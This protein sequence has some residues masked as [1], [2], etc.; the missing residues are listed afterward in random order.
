[1]MIDGRFVLVDNYDDN[2]NQ[3]SDISDQMYS[4][5]MVILR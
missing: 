2:L 5:F 4:N 3:L 1:M